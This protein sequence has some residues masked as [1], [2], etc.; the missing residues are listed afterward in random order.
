MDAGIHLALLP[1][2]PQHS[3]LLG[4]LRKLNAVAEGAKDDGPNDVAQQPGAASVSY[5]SGKAYMRP[6][7][8]SAL[9]G[10]RSRQP[11]KR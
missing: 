6:G 4:E 7:Q 8:G 9:F 1:S 3:G 10:S 11:C 5:D 2:A